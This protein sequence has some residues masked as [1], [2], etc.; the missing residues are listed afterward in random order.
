LDGVKVAN[1][2]RH[3][4]VEQTGSSANDRAI[5]FKRHK[6]E[7][8][9]R[10]KVS[11]AHNSIPVQTQ[12]GINHEFP[13]N[14]PM[15]LREGGDFADSKRRSTRSG[16][17]YALC[18]G[19]VVPTNKNRVVAKSTRNAC[20]IKFDAK[21]KRMLPSQ[22]ERARVIAFLPLKAASLTPSLSEVVAGVPVR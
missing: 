11:M 1:R 3:T 5:V 18:E 4:I 19:A 2:Q 7:G 16:E 21:S 12:S 9:A 6:H 8:D 20:V 13:V 15:V 17:V 10:R 22:R 14:G